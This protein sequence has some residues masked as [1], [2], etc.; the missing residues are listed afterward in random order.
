MLVCGQSRKSDGVRYKQSCCGV[1]YDGRLGTCFADRLVDLTARRPSGWL[2]RKTYG[3]ML[4]A[5]K[6]HEEVFDRVLQLLQP[7]ADERCLEIGCGGGRL[8]ERLLA[9]GGSAAGLDHSPD[10]LAL[11][12]ERNREA[13]EHGR[14]ELKL[15]DASQL[16]WPEDTFSS[17]VSANTFFFVAHPDRLLAEIL[18]VLK[19][20]GRAIIATVPGPLPPGSLRNW[21]VYV[22]GARMHVYDDQTMRSLVQ[23]A[24]FR[25]VLVTSDTS[26]S[27]PLQIVDA[28]P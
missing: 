21:W 19:P 16:P 8:L 27:E 2:A 1:L 22:W 18:R 17:V 14:L 26:R 10:M 24:G 25:N 3:G 9:S 4:G 13:V 20:D 12:T 6:G 11:S 28:A 23:D 5:P 15:G 7:A